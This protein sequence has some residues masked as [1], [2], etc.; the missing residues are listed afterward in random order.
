VRVHD[1][2]S[3]DT[4]NVTPVSFGGRA[5]ERQRLLRRSGLIAAV[6]VLVALVLLVSGHWILGIIVGVAAVAAVWVYLQA[7]QVR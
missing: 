6:L 2:R 7:R 4:G 5:Q 1:T 3:R